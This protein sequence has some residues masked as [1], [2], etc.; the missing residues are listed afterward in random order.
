M[1]RFANARTKNTRAVRQLGV[2]AYCSAVRLNVFLPPPRVLLI[3]PAKSGTHLLSDCL[4]LMPRMMFSGRH[5]AGSEFADSSDGLE[6]MPTEDPERV[7][8][9]DGGRLRKYLNACPLGMFVTAHVSF[10][11]VVQ[12]VSTELGFKRLLLLRDPRDIAV[13]FALSPLKRNSWHH[14]H[15]QYT[16]VLTTDE[17][18]I[19]ATIRGFERSTATDT[20]L[21]SIGK[22]LEGYEGWFYDPQT[23]V[24][25]FEDL[26]GPRGG[27][28]NEK[29]IEEIQRIGGFVGRP[30]DREQAERIALEMYGESS[31]T[32]RKGKVG[33][34][35]NHFTQE[36]REAFKEVASDVLIQMG[37]EKNAD[38]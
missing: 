26:V 17:E 29:Q 7:T 31:L 36:H 12:D 22:I 33:D 18:R 27:G 5:F 34:W 32:Y 19:M 20:P 3:G 13:S 14:H 35:R 28:S 23:M 2:R 25:R 30:L 15:A 4:S 21:E 10:N 24:V 37:Y 11:P 38:W 9:V 8:S 1:V 16:K 6:E